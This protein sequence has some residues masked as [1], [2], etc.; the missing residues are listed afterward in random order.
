MN[1]LIFGSTT[2]AAEAFEEIAKKNKSISIFN[3]SRNVSNKYFIDLDNPQNI[4][5]EILLQATIW[6]SFAPIWKLNYFFNYISK[7]N[8]SLLLNLKLLILCS[9]SSV[10]TKRF[11]FNLYDKKALYVSGV[12]LLKIFR[13]IFPYS[14]ISN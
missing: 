1:I 7:N 10:I 9:S 14:L 6:V 5:K 8:S 4:N 2:P 13:S 11:S 12:H 3:S